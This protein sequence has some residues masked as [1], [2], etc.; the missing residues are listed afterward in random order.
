[1]KS[2]RGASPVFGTAD[3]MNYC[4]AEPGTFDPAERNTV[5]KIKRAKKHNTVVFLLYS[6]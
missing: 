6:E 3:L 5:R 2:G 1:M 4:S